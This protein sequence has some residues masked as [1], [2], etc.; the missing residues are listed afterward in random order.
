MLPRLLVSLA[1]AATIAVVAFLTPTIVTGRL[2]VSDAP[3]PPELERVMDSARSAVHAELEGFYGLRVADM[4]Y[5]PPSA[6][7]SFEV[8]GFFAPVATVTATSHSSRS[9]SDP[10]WRIDIPAPTP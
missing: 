8:L 9:D 5:R 6:T 1:V 10:G 3:Y 2:F 4:R 7:V